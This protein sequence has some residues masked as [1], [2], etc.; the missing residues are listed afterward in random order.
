MN[1]IVLDKLQETID[2]KSTEFATV[3]EEGLLES[4]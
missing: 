3:F 4:V 1:V 2:T